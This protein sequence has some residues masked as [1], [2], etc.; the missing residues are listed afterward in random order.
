[1]S[2]KRPRGIVV[3][4]LL[5]IAFGLAEVTTGLTHN[6][7]GLST[8]GGTAS[9]YAGSAIGVLYAVA[10]LLILSMTKRAAAIAIVLLIA[11][12]I[13]RIAM[14][15]T[16]LYSVDSVRQAFAIMLGTI[17]VAAFAVYIRS[18]WSSFT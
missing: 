8:V 3:A 18:K 11:D 2:R 16:G 13:G 7:F 4:A 1:M 6:F 14:V 12:I 9:A 15:G 17:I 5:M 10:G